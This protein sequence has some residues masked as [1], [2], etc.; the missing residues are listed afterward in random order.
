MCHVRASTH[1]SAR[2]ATEQL[3]HSRVTSHTSHIIRHT[4]HVIRQSSHVTRHTSHVTRH[5]SHVIRHT[6]YVTRHTSHVTRQSLDTTAASPI[7]HVFQA[8]SASRTCS[9]CTSILVVAAHVLHSAVS[10]DCS[11]KQRPTATASCTMHSVRRMSR[12][13]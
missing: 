5:K 8:P 2:A 6:S 9:G 7:K 12:L 11:Y 3:M 10:R 4:S 1:S 13:Q